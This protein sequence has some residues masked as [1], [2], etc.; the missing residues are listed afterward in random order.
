[1]QVA[2]LSWLWAALL[3]L[4]ARAALCEVEPPP[5]SQ[6]EWGELRERFSAKQLDIALGFTNRPEGYQVQIRKLILEI[7]PMAAAL[8]DSPLK[9][10]DSKYGRTL[11][12]DLSSLL[13]I[14]TPGTIA[15]IWSPEDPER[16]SEGYLESFVAYHALRYMAKEMEEYINGATLTMPYPIE[17]DEW[18]QARFISLGLATRDLLHATCHLGVFE[19]GSAVAGAVVGI[20][21]LGLFP[22]SQLS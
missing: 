1:M 9:M 12:L 13:T 3:P 15:A 16:T 5:Q 10:K 17:L 6:E 18:Q 8:R 14:F 20:P 19:A 22:R 11:E 4:L 7:L 21:Q 2:W